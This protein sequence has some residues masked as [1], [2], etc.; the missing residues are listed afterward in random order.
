MKLVP[1][2]LI[3]AR[4]MRRDLPPHSWPLALV[5][6]CVPLLLGGVAAAEPHERGRSQAAAVSPV[7]RVALDEALKHLTE[8]RRRSQL[9]GGAADV[10]GVYGA[11]VCGA[12]G[13][14][15]RAGCMEAAAISLVD[16]RSLRGL[17]AGM[18]LCGPELE[19]RLELYEGLV[20]A[21]DSAGMGLA[22]GLLRKEQEL[23]LDQ[24]EGLV[25]KLAARRLA[26]LGLQ[27][28][29]KLDLAQL[30]AR[31]SPGN[32]GP[33]PRRVA[34]LA[35]AHALYESV[36]EE[37]E[38][39]TY[40]SRAGSALWRLEHLSLGRV[41][42]DFLTHDVAGNEIRLSDFRGQVVVVHF[43]D[44]STLDLG[45]ALSLSGAKGRRHWDS[46]FAW[47]GIHRG[48]TPVALQAAMDTALPCG[49]HAWEGGE[50]SGAAQAWRIP[51]GETI[52]VIGPAGFICAMNPAESL[53]DRHITD[54]LGD[55]QIQSRKRQAS[56]GGGRDGPERPGGGGANR[57]LL[58][59]V[60]RRDGGSQGGE[61]LLQ[62]DQAP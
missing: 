29:A 33:E 19:D 46:R 11:D 36:E 4:V 41:A 49:E 10:A 27:A 39:T 9:A 58:D 38:G 5:T 23:G 53:L 56:S 44:S 32:A 42:P 45:A 1:H 24:I 14:L 20:R 47:V 60:S 37:F 40:A 43:T 7:R 30:L 8:I 17:P 51:V 52:A 48:G 59:G 25:R 34:R 31:C 54:L 22:L 62:G 21:F 3:A 35:E 18:S 2:F 50:S 26:P 16:Y 13:V 61:A 12:L 28:Q 15:A 6:L 57:G 55:L